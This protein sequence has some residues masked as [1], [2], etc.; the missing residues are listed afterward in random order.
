[1]ERSLH[2]HRAVIREFTISD[3][4]VHIAV[5]RDWDCCLA[6][7]EPS[8]PEG[9]GGEKCGTPRRVQPIRGNWSLATGERGYADL[10][11]SG[12]TGSDS[13][14]LIF[15]EKTAASAK[16]D[17]VACVGFLILQILFGNITH[18]RRG[19]LTAE[20]NYRQFRFPNELHFQALPK[21]QY[22]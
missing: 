13:R 3:Q 16:S 19:L 12:S 7:R 22:L 4:S 6:D 15:H 5:L 2:F 14:W 17:N 10:D 21:Q 1:M 18:I 8:A 20:S 11:K 9:R